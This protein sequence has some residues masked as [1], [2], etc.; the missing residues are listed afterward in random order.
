MMGGD[1]VCNPPHKVGRW[2]GSPPIKKVKLYT[3]G[4]AGSDIQKNKDAPIQNMSHEFY[5]IT[6]ERSKIPSFSR[7]L[8]EDRHYST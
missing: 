4:F 3:L 8:K 7:T 1:V 2:G 6:F 5:P